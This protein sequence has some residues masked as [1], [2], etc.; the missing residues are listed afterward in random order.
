M[1]VV[2][3]DNLSKPQVTKETNDDDKCIYP[4]GTEVPPNKK[5]QK[6][7]ASTTTSE[8]VQSSTAA[9]KPQ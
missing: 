7:T 3:P 1:G 2:F 8:P 5:V 4:A 9:L 6:G